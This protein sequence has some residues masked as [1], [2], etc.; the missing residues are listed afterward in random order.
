MAMNSAIGILNGNRK[1][2]RPYHVGVAGGIAFAVALAIGLGVFGGARSSSAVITSSG[3]AGAELRT[4]PLP[5]LV[6]YYL[7]ETQDEAEAIGQTFAQGAIQLISLN[8]E[9]PNV[10][11]NYVVS[12]TPEEDVEV[13]EMIVDVSFSL[14][15]ANGD[16]E[17]I[18]MRRP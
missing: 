12:G 14:M 18:D 7:V 3:S 2:I 13:D 9:L 17:V 6:Q 11:R 4:A 5:K 8:M 10:V 15:G 16:L 1:H